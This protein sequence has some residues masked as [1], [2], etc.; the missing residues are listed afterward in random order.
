MRHGATEWSVN[1]RHTGI[2]DLALL[3]QGE[4]QARAVGRLL[5][6][7]P[8][9]LVLTSPLHRARHT[10]ELAG[11]ADRAEIDADLLEWDYGEF[12]GV[13]TAEIRRTI[14]DWTV[15]TGPVPNGE[16]IH[17]VARRVDRVIARARAAPGDTVVFAHGHVLRVL[18]A[19]WCDLDPVEG[20]RLPLETATLS[21]LGWERET[22][23]IHLWNSRG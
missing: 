10:C 12:E 17:Q 22:P 5:D 19:R 20:R 8:F 14:P 2:T 11:Y 15:F 16:T 18:A 3:P 21:V 1:G 7:R 4:E 6:G 9:A 13:T 23:C